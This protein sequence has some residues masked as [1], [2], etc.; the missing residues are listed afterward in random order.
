MGS[1]KHGCLKHKDHA[2]DCGMLITPSDQH[3]AILPWSSYF[4]W[5]PS[6]RAVTG[7]LP[8]PAA[9]LLLDDLA[10]DHLSKIRKSVVGEIMR[11]RAQQAR[12]RFDINGECY[13]SRAMPCNAPRPSS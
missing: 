2:Q 10:H 11:K 13:A 4:G 5:H 9:G 12:V 7:I 8:R 3:P 6:L 1:R